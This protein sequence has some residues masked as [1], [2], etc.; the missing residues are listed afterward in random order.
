MC[1]S[2][3]SPLQTSTTNEEEKDLRIIDSKTK[4]KRMKVVGTESLE[5]EGT[6]EGR[7]S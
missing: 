4:R 2:S 6:E 3:L 1:F 5:L 7:N